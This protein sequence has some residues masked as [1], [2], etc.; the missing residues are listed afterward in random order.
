MRDPPHRDGPRRG[1]RRIDR[2]SGKGGRVGRELLAGPNQ[3]RAAVVCCTPRRSTAVG[4]DRLFRWSLDPVAAEDAIDILRHHP[5]AAVGW[6]D[7][8]DAAVHADPRTRDSI[9]LGVRQSLASLAD[10]TVRAAVD[11]ADGEEFDAEAFLR[12]R[13]TLFLLGTGTGV[14]AAAGLLAALSK[15]SPKPPGASPPAPPVPG[16]TRPSPWS[17]TR[18]PTCPRCRRCP[19]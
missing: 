7:G 10:P 11:P 9:W 4:V 17:S 3:G 6:E 18:S 12:S 1:A 8:I 13:G 15:T 5:D 19:R 16:S 14:G 2:V